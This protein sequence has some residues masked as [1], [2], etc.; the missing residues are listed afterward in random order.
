M[1]SPPATSELEPG[2]RGPSAHPRIHHTVQEQER[3][4]CPPRTDPST[5]WCGGAHTRPTPRARPSWTQK[6]GR[7]RGLQSWLPDP[8]AEWPKASGSFLSVPP[9]LQWKMEGI[10]G[11]IWRERSQEGRELLAITARGRCI[12]GPGVNIILAQPPSENT[13]G[14]WANRLP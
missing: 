2:V 4:P 7:G 1:E 11:K 5:Q 8:P 12:S 6:R 10:L 14:P 13:V 9:F 3:G